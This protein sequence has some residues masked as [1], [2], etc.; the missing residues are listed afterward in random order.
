MGADLEQTRQRL[1]HSSSNKRERERERDDSARFSSGEENLFLLGRLAKL[2]CR[3]Y[4]VESG[5]VHCLLANEH[6]QS[7]E[8]KVP[9]G[10]VNYID[11][12]GIETGLQLG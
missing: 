6:R 4:A 7:R 12:T 8:H 5:I 10:V 11:L 3:N 1:R 9:C 2:V